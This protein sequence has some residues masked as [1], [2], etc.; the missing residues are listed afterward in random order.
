M[1]DGFARIALTAGI[2]LAP[3]CASAPVAHADPACA[4][5]SGDSYQRCA[6]AVQQDLQANLDAC[7]HLFMGTAAQIQQCKDQVRT[8]IQ[9]APPAHET[10]TSAQAPSST[11]A[12]E[13]STTSAE[14]PSASPPQPPT[15]K[16]AAI[17]PPKS[18]TASSSAIDAAKSNRTQVDPA[19]PPKPPTDKTF[20]QRVQDVLRHHRGNLD[21]VKGQAHPRLWDFID[22]DEYHRPV[23]Y[24]PMSEGM[25][26]RYFYQGD[27]REAYVEASSSVALN[28]SV[29]GVFPFT[30]VGEDYL[31]SGCF[32]GGAWVPPDGWTGPPPLDYTAP[33]QTLYED[34]AV[35]LPAYGQT[36]GVGDVQP[37]G[38]DDSQPAGSQDTFMLN[39][40]TLAWGQ[41]NQPGDN[42]QITVTKTQTLPGVGPTDD[43]KSLVDLAAASEPQSNNTGMVVALV[44][45][46]GLAVLALG[47]CIWVFI[48]RRK[49][50]A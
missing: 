8:D 29:G 3:I 35:Y 44:I 5:L 38:H 19:N 46:I 23:F 31:T 20:D 50:T 6:A 18:L 33:Q 27:Y 49:R 45:G 30:A 1:N 9:V 4:G 47:V 32:N 24:N 36:V 37:V 39:G 26:F 28:V 13:P 10:T 43:G 21:V 2:T 22:Y 14:A 15:S 41:A 12:E 48:R 34:V 25:T 11:P 16:P 42:G 7:D 17:K 40:S